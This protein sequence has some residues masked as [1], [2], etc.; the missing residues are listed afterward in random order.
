MWFEP[1]PKVKGMRVVV[2][3]R[4]LLG[5]VCGMWVVWVRVSHTRAP[6]CP[7]EPV[8][9]LASCVR[10]HIEPRPKAEGYWV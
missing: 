2:W 8:S 1:R 9:P 10:R 6:S 4:G 7:V 3:V 5:A